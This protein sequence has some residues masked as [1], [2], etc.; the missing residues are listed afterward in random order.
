MID[1]RP[2]TYADVD[3]IMSFR[4][5][6]YANDEIPPDQMAARAAL[7]DLLATPAF[8]SVWLI[9]RDG[10]P[11][12]YLVITHSY[13]IEFR[14]RD[15]F[16]DELFIHEKARGQGIGTM[17]LR[18]AETHCRA[19]GIHA[20]HLEVDRDNIA[21]QRFYRRGGF[22]DHERYLMTRWLV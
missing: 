18:F 3:V 9:V 10:D 2:A 5:Q 12:G 8:G 19:L 13:S 1:F 14:G 16:I 17:A 20:V 4:R 21:A 7:E 15:A 6:L 22:Q 11:V